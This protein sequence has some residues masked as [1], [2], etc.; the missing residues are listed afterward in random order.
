MKKKNDVK[1]KEM[2]Q[3]K[4]SYMKR[5]K[6]KVKK[7]KEKEERIIYRE[8]K[9]YIQREEQWKILYERMREDIE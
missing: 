5:K 8:R 3:E 6:G 1:K 7:E 4:E 2:Y 9:G